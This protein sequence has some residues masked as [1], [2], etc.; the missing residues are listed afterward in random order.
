LLSEGP[1]AATS[2]LG[3]VGV[4]AGWRLVPEDPTAEMMTA[5]DKAYRLASGTW[6]ESGKWVERDQP[7]YAGL[8]GIVPAY[9]AMLSA[10]PLPPA[11]TQGEE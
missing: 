11:P 8:D 6:G 7:R 9:R 4:P 2:W 3:G 5:G 10:A 1:S